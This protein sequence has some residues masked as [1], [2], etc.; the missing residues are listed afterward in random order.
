MQK[1]LRYLFM[2]ILTMTVGNVMA[3]E[4]TLAYSGDATTNMTAGNNAATVGLDESEWSVVPDKGGNNNYPGLNKAHDIRLY[5]GNTLTVSSSSGATINSI[6]ITFTGSSYSNVTVKVGE[7]TISLTDGVYAINSS[8]FV[9]GNGKEDNTQVRISSVVINYTAPV[10]GKTSTTIELSGDYLT[11]F[12]AGKDGKAADLP[13]ATVKAGDA[14]VAGASVT[15]ALTKGSNWHTGEAEPAIEG[16][17]VTIANQS[18]GDLM[19]KASYAGNDTYKE[20]SKSYSLKVYKGRMNI[21]EILEDFPEVGGDSWSGASAEWTAGQQT[22]FWEVKEVNEEFEH[23][24]ALVTYVNGQYTYIKD[25][26]G[27]LL[28]YGSNLGFEKGQKIT[29]DVEN[30]GAIWGTLKAYNGLLELV[31]TKDDCGFVVKSSDNEVTPKVITAEGFTQANM[32]EYVKVEKAE[33]I[34]ADSKTLIFKVGEVNLTVYNQ[35]SVATTDLVAGNL[36]D[37]IGMGAIRYASNTLTFQIY[38]I[39][40][41]LKAVKPTV[42]FADE[43]K[44]IEMGTTGYVNKVTKTP[45]TLAVG[46]RSENNAVATAASWTGEIS[47]IAPG[48][49]TITCTWSEQV[50]ENVTYLAGS[51]TYELTVTESGVAATPGVAVDKEEA[52]E[53]ETVT[54]TFSH[55]VLNEGNEVTFYYTTDGTEPTTDSPN[56]TFDDADGASV[57][58]VMG[59]AD[60]SICAK[61]Y[62]EGKE[63]SAASDAVTVTFKEASDGSVALPYTNSLL[64]TTIPEGFSVAGDEGVWTYTSNYGVKASAGS[65]VE[66]EAYLITPFVDMTNATAPTMQFEHAG[67]FFGTP[68]NEATLWAREK[69]GEWQQLTIET[70]FSNSNWNFSTTQVDIASL[71]GKKVQFGF[72]YNSTTSNYGTW[73]IK[74]LAI[75]DG[76]VVITYDDH[77]IAS[78]NEA[79][80]AIERVN[81]TLTDAEITYVNGDRAYVTE[82]DASIL[83]FKSGLFTAEHVGK[84]VSGTVKV[85]LDIYK[86]LKEVVKIAD[87]TNADDLTFSAAAVTPEPEKVTVEDIVSGNAGT[88]EYVTLK[89][90]LKIVVEEASSAPE[91]Q[92][93][94]GD[95][96]YY[97]VSGTTEVLLHNQFGINFDELTDG[98]DIEITGVVS[99]YNGTPQ[100][101]P[102]TVAA[103][104]TGINSLEM[105]EALTEGKVYTLSGQ[106][107]DKNFKGIVV[108]NGKKLL[109][110]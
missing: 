102:I 107:V 94:P 104:T 98:Q 103:S 97:A 41:T 18:Y 106:R 33:F 1:L 6:T 39:E 51:T 15:W 83:F 46:F 40:F 22:S 92:L 64:G 56:A 3:D 89:A 12:T 100:L 17:T 28:L 71:A 62:V 67:K 7:N 34:S 57:E 32:N 54:I 79:T 109:K 9:L 24:E 11:K 27:S 21:Q 105:D 95:K 96:T 78:L 23:I 52:A 68:A 101:L 70:Y 53:G 8:S 63:L 19:L 35:W 48:T 73:E 80:A 38:P 69:D 85:K 110:K 10:G 60:L 72:K 55:P 43:N 2:A 99:V 30:N 14:T 90:K 5:K 61:A 65:A 45:A 25:E 42:T 88:S 77:T 84:T 91:L 86:G 37:I 108:M 50:I 4:V 66:K 36:Y 13:T 44:S 26:A 49:A 20:S 81:L 58:V 59:T 82:G 29:G 75:A 93:A 76:E 74:N 16:S 87:V 47:T 31:T